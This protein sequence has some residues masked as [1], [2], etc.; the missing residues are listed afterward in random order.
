MQSWPV[1]DCDRVSVYSEHFDPPLEGAGLLHGLD[2]VWVP[3]PQ[4]AEQSDHG[5]KLPR[6]PSTEI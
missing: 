5:D 4:L 2:L 6:P 3:S 1:Q